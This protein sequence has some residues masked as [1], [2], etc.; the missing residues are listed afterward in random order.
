MQLLLSEL[1]RFA[2]PVICSLTDGGADKSNGSSRQGALQ[3]PVATVVA[4]GGRGVYR[5][6]QVGGL[7]VCVD[8]QSS[9]TGWVHILCGRSRVLEDCV[10]W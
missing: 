2:A 9:G 7:Q 5:T 4:R 6:A 8:P 3:T 1:P 10:C